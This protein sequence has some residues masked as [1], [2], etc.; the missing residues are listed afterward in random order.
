MY[1]GT[2]ACSIAPWRIFITWDIW[3]GF[4]SGN[5]NPVA[6]YSGDP[7]RALAALLLCRVDLEPHFRRA[8]DKAG[9]KSNPPSTRRRIIMRRIRGSTRSHKLELA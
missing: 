7:V 9:C 3:A 2:V 4:G 5:L 6:S 8:A 1:W